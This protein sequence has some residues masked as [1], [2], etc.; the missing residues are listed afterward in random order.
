MTKTNATNQNDEIV[1]VG[2]SRKINVKK[3]SEENSNYVM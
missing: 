1:N 2:M 3:E